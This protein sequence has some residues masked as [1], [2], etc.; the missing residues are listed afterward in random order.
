MWRDPGPVIIDSDDDTI[1]RLLSFRLAP[2]RCPLERYAHRAAGFRKGAS[3][4][5]EVGDNLGETG[6]VAK[7]EIVGACV[8]AT[9][10][11][12]GQFDLGA[13]AARGIPRHGRDRAQ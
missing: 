1:E 13:A 8:L 6:I 2:G 11:G 9:P 7:D 10:D 12:D 5:N 4:V 3:V